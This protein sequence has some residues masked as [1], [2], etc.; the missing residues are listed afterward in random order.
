MT[1]AI[2]L[3]MTGCLFLAV[4]AMIDLLQSPIPCATSSLWTIKSAYSWPCWPGPVPSLCHW[5]Q[6]LQFLPFCGHSV[7]N[8]FTCEVQE[9]LKLVCSDTPGRLILGLVIGIFTL[10]LPFTF[11]LFSYAHIVVAVLRI[12]S[13]EARLKAFSTC[14][15]HLT[16]IIIFY[17]TVTYM[18]LKPQSRESQDKG[19]VISVFFWKR[20]FIIL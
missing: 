13:A 8:H 15:S 2:F 12:N 16:V 1:S 20:F 6:S 4:M 14:G 9:L 17:G 10:P 11:I 7:I 18:H 19:K 3:G 5:Y